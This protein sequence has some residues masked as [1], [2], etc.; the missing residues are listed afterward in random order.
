MGERAWGEWRRVK[1]VEGAVVRVIVRGMLRR[2]DVSFGILLREELILVVYR[3]VLLLVERMR[4]LEL[5]S[6]RC[7]A[8]SDRTSV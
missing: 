4:R 5:A 1:W 3:D 8:A 7:C 2:R 6:S